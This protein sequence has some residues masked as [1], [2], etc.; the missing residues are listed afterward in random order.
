MKTVRLM[1]HAGSDIESS[2]L[3]MSDIEEAEKNDPLL[4]SARI[5]INDRILSSDEILDLYEKTRTRIHYVFEKATTRPRLDEASDIMGVI[6]PN[7]SKK[8]IPDL[9]NEKMRAKIF[10]KEYKRLAQ[11]NHMAK[12]INYALKDI[13]LQYDNT[14]VFGEDVAKKG[15]VYH[16]TVDLFNQFSIRRVFNSPLDETSIIGFAAGLAH[17]GFLPI[18]EIQF[19]AYFH[20]AEDQLRGEAATLSFFSQGQYINPM[21]IRIAGL[22][23]QKGFGGHFHN[24]NSLTIFR[25]IPGVILACPSNGS[26]AVK[27]LRTATREAYT[28]GRIVVFI[29]P[30]ALYMVKDLHQPSDD[31]WSSKYSE[32]NE[33]LKL[34]EFVTYGKGKAL[35]I[36]SYGNGLYH[37]LKAQ[38]QIEKIINRKIKI[39]DICWLSDIDIDGL[40][41]EIGNSEKVLIVDECRKSGCHGEGLLAS[42]YKKSKGHLSIKLHAAEDSFIPLGVA[43][44]STLPNYETIIRH[45]IELYKN[46]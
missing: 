15:G 23:Y 42:L 5:L 21:V 46:A 11:P 24:D 27:M 31:K 38:P 35:T 13:M 41:K 29:E 33:E 34:G 12:L 1:G 37:S 19:L 25:D 32:I 8:N 2:Y 18:P 40:I 7:D 43:A 10:G 22:A 44:T 9:T 16:I 45:S 14:L 3:S 20:N 4:H 30:I 36:I 6:V 28:N 26:D 39:I 17:N